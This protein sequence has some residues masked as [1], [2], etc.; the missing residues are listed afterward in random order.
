MADVTCDPV[1]CNGLELDLSPF[2]R[3]VGQNHDFDECAM[4]CAAPYGRAVSPLTSAL[5]R[6]VQSHSVG[7]ADAQRHAHPR[8]QTHAG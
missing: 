2:P 1:S 4:R 7:E 3:L 5:R 8:A 6:V